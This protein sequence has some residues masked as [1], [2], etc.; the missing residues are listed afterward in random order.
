MQPI[1]AFSIVPADLRHLDAMMAVMHAA[2]DPLYGEAWSAPQLAGTLTMPGCWAR[3]AMAG[4]VATGFSLCRSLGPEVELLLIAVD[5]A[6]RRQ[7]IAA[8]LLARA[9]DDAS[10]RGASE[11]FLEVREDNAAALRLYANAGFGAVGRRRDY[12]TGKDGS[13]RSAITMKTALHK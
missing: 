4:A 2:F 10:A 11:L 9:Q 5:P 3:L 13:K 6:Q 7:G 12:Y 8:R 1:P